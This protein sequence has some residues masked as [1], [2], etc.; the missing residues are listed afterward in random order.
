M[1]DPNIPAPAAKKTSPWLYVGLGCGGLILLLIIALGVRGWLGKIYGEDNVLE[2]KSFEQFAAEMEAD[3]EFTAVE[4]MIRLNPEIELVSSNK[5]A[6]T[7][8]LRQK[9]DGSE[10]TISIADLQEGKLSFE[11]DGQVT[12]MDAADGQLA[13]TQTT[14]DGQTQTLTYGIGAIEEH[15]AYATALVLP[16]AQGVQSAMLMDSEEG[17]FGSFF[18]TTGKSVEDTATELQ[19]LGTQQGIEFERTPM[20]SG[21]GTFITL[22]KPQADDG[23]VLTLMLNQEAQGTKVTVSYQEPKQ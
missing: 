22:S 12:Q 5:E 7:V 3:P 10:T 19:A 17:K 9:S 2:G 11:Q 14:A 16:E 15:S 1:T 4:T 18:Y 23:K 6:G 13:V 20:E 8:T 21:D